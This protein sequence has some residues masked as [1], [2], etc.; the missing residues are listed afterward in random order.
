MA[1]PSPTKVAVVGTGYVGL[2][3]GACL[4]DVGA[5]V[6]CID[7]D[8]ARI[9]PLRQGRIPFHEPGL[10]DVVLRAVAAGR[11]RFTTDLAAGV[12]D[13]AVAFIA[14]GT[15][16]GDDGAADLRYVHAA[17]DQLAKAL[18]KGAVVAIR[19]TVPAGTGDALQRRL[20][21]AGRADLAVVNAPEFLAEGTA[22]RDFRE[23]DRIV[24]GGPA[25]ACDQVLALFANLRPAA[26]R[27]RMARASA[28]LAKAAANAFLAARVSLINE[29]AAVC[30]AVGADVRDVANAVGL[31]N[32]VGPKFLRPGIGYGGSCFPKDV[33]ALDAQ[34]RRLG[35][36]A[37]LV[38]AIQE[39]NRR[40]LRRTL[41]K[42]K[43]LAGGSLQGKQVAVW[44][45][46]FKPGTDDVREAP[47]VALMRE[48]VAL[49]ATVAAH[50]PKAPLPKA[51]RDAGVAQVDT[52]LQAAQ[53]A[54]LL[55]VATEWPEYAAV[56]ATDVLAALRAPAV[57]D[58][59]N[60]LDHAAYARAGARLAA[61]GIPVPSPSTAPA[62]QA[63]VAGNASPRKGGAA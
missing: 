23:P 33:A 4:A 37:A 51:L 24:V 44:G 22:V 38:P 63:H 57:L 26:P 28:E 13:A 17:G 8:A 9:E 58:G 48:L 29:V 11:L 50:D 30:D 61:V 35:I 27:L 56:P 10:S 2:V 45:I 18:P 14:V 32:R 54:H 52:P 20:D 7:V 15:P 39:T 6:T 34:A 43:A 36:E 16:Q 12:R 40:Q 49:G 59:R 19:S 41:A 46:A 53:G 62:P 1:Q 5:A 25:P 60:C 21:A 42:A 55:V 31:D 3:T 47:A